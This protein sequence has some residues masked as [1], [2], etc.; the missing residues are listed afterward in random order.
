MTD[1]LTAVEVDH[2]LAELLARRIARHER[3]CPRARRGPICRSPMGTF[4]VG[5]CFT[6]LHH[7][8]TDDLQDRLLSELARVVRAG[9]LGARLRRHCQRRT[10]RRCMRTTRTTRSIRPDCRSACAVPAWTT[11]RSSTTSTRSASAGLSAERSR[12]LRPVRAAWRVIIA[13]DR[14]GRRPLRHRRRQPPHGATPTR[15][16]SWPPATPRW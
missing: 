14:A 6:M 7:V 10:S 1:M 8:P 4:S 5:M 3:R 13:A 2:D 15:S 12:R 16:P 11:S 9:R